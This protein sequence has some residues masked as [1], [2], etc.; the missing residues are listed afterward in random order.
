VEVPESRIWIFL[1]LTAAAAVGIPLGVRRMRR[2]SQEQVALALAS[3]ERLGH[4]VEQ[5]VSQHGRPFVRV[6]GFLE[7]PVAIDLRIRRRGALLGRL[8]PQSEGLFDAAFA[9]AY[10]VKSSEPER[11]RLILDPDIQQRLTRLR[12][13]EF[14]LGSLET[15]LPP[16]YWRG[17]GPGPERRLRRL[18]MLRVPG[19]EKD[20]AREELVRVGRMLARSVAAH[21]LPPGTPDPADFLTARSEL[22]WL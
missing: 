19:R 10:R 2:Q 15:L 4:V 20:V 7:H 9:A 22:P 1:A 3:L 5:A 14:R 21:C 12:G 13:L 8:A 11:V 17:R 16:D 18:W 6:W